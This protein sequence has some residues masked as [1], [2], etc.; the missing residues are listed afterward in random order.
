VKVPAC[1]LG[2]Q[3]IVIAVASPPR[4]SIRPVCGVTEKDGWESGEK[5]AK[6]SSNVMQT[7][8]T[9]I[10]MAAPDRYQARDEPMPKNSCK[11]IKIL[12]QT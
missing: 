9:W 11:I 12:E 2:L 5:A 4:R 6:K 3:V 1:P 8:C 10:S 7:G